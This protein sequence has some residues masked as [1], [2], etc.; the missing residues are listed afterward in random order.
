MSSSS[1][2]GG[3]GPARPGPSGAS[4]PAADEAA[5]SDGPRWRG[6]LGELVFAGL[7]LALGVFAFVGASSIRVPESANAVGP[8]AFP[9]LVGGILIVSSVGVL[10][11]VLRGRASSQE[12]GEDIDSAAATDWRTLAKIVIAVIAHI[13]LV[14]VI[15]WAFAA[16][17][18]FAIVAWALG[19]RRWW[20][21]ALVG[22]ALGLAIQLGFGLGL[23]LSLPLGPVLGP[24]LGA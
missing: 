11:E 18:L 3:V 21:A 9:Y 6:R 1:T 5:A 16:A 7:A 22:L 17:L 4:V 24:L 20:V 12:E 19:A 14:T 8:T 15:G 10:V 13:A 2:H 23:G